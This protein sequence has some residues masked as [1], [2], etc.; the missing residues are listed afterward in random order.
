VPAEDGFEQLRKIKAP[1]L[2]AQLIDA[3]RESSERFGS[4]LTAE[5][6]K[7]T[8]SSFLNLVVVNQ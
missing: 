4:T 1:V 8:G 6:Q 2:R 3:I 7:D 5:R